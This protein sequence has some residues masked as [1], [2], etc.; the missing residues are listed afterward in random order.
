MSILR[1]SLVRVGI[2]AVCS[3]VALEAQEPGALV[4]R[5]PASPR[6][7]GLGDAFVGGRGSDVVFYNPAQIRLVAGFFGTVTRYG[8]A[9]TQAAMASSTTLGKLTVA[10]FTQWLDHEADRFPARPGGL[11]ET[12]QF[13]AQ[14]L[15]LG[16][17]AAIEIKGVRVG[18]AGKYVE[19]R[20]TVARGGVAAFDVG[21]GR[22][23]D[24][25]SVGLAVQHLGA[26]LTA[27]TA[28]KLPTRVTLG[29]VTRPYPIG[30]FLD[31]SAAL[32]VSRERGG[33]IAPAG[34]L[35]LR[36][37]PLAG[38]TV[39]ARAG[40]RRV[41]GEGRPGLQP[42]TAGLSLGLDRLSV[43]YGFESY[44]GTGAAHRFGIRIE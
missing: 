24:W 14:S 11:T 44:R 34:G 36:Y 6:A 41:D 10:G 9:S 12:G 15:A 3:S 30:T 38:W 1:S 20:H 17:A 21:V 4:L 29:G 25:L 43:D 42:I 37:E 23:V 18:V 28:A 5:V 19:D 31:L 2:V 16:G 39:T 13:H 27:G 32:S 8:G 26:D 33:T 7:F 40:A 22:Q 35:Q